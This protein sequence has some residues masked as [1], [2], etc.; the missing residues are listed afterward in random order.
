MEL[1]ELSK[2]GLGA[3]LGVGAG[4][5]TIDISDFVFS[6]RPVLLGGSTSCRI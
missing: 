6:I 4:G 1:E 2:R 3:D 5:D